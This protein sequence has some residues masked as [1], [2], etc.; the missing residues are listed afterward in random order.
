VAVLAFLFYWSDFIGPIL[1]LRSPDLYTLPMGLRQL[2]QLDRQDWPLLM[3]GAT[4]LAV[5]AILFFLF[6]QARF[7]GQVRVP[8]EV[9]R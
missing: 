1:Y 8:E 3:V 4:L 9:E 5:P 7:L 6:L 2:Q